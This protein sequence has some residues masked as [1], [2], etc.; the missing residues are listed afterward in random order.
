MRYTFLRSFIF[1][2]LSFNS[3]FSNAQYFGR[4][5]VLYEDFDFR[6]NR[7]PHFDI[8][9]YLENENQKQLLAWRTEQW[10]LMHM[11]VLRDSFVERNPFII[12]NHHAHFQQTRVIGGQIDVSTGGVTEGFKN[13][14]IMPFMESNA[15]TDHVLGHELVHAFQYHII[16][17]SFSLNA[18]NNLPLWMVEGMAEYLS[19]GY[20]DA[21]TA[22]WLRSALQNKR[23]PSL[24]DLTNRPDLY[25]PYRWGQAFWAYVSGLYGDGIIRKLFT[26][27]AANGYAAAI[28]KV[29]GMDEATF[30]KQWQE[31][32]RNAYSPFQTKTQPA[33]SGNSLINSNNAGELNIVPSI[34]PDG[35]YIAYWTEKNL[36][37]LDLFIANA[38]TGEVTERITRNSYNAHIDQY[39]SYESKVAWSPDSRQIAFVVFA[40]GRNELVVADINGK[41]TQ[42]LRIPGVDGFSNPAWSPDGKTIVLTGLVEGQSDLYAYS[43]QN[44]TV[45]KLTN[46]IYAD[47]HPSFSPDGKYIVFSTDRISIGNNTLQHRYNHNLAL[48]NIATGSITNLDFFPGADNLNPVFAP[49]N[50]IIY[51]LSDRDGFRNIYSYDLQDKTLQQKTNLFTGITGI[52]SFAPAISVS[53]QTGKLAYSYFSNGSYTIITAVP[54]QLE[55]IE[56]QP[57]N[58]NRAAAVLPPL[59]RLGK[60]IVQNNLSTPPSLTAA[61]TTITE[62]PY[63]SKFELDYLG[64]T[65]IGIQTGGSFGTGLAGGVNGIFSD[66]LGNHQMFGALSLSGEILDFGGQFA[67]INQNN[68]INWGLSASHIPYLSGAEYLFPDTV[69]NVQGDTIEVINNSLDLL[70]TFEDQLS[71]FASYPF[72]TIRRI[73]LGASF[74]RYYYRMDRYT[75]YY[76]P[77]GTIYLGNTREKQPVPGGFNFGNSYLAYVGDN[78]FFGVASPLAGHRFRLQA[79]QYFGVVNMTNLMGDYRKYFRMEPI[80]LATRN[81]YVGRFGKDAETGILA[82]LFLGYPTLIRGYDAVGYKDDKGGNLTIN[83]LIGS[84]IYVS[85]V[86]LRLPLTGPER[87][88]AITSRFLFTEIN[89]FTDG[90]IAWGQRNPAPGIDFKQESFINRQSRFILSSGISLRLNLFG[91]LILEP[92][93]AVPWQNGGFKNTNFGF[94][95]VPGW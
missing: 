67:Y 4:N 19:I 39:S 53:H 75:D 34:S 50:R 56:L 72:S 71:V 55:T 82:P 35:R 64:N 95:F 80:T 29:L 9:N 59:A 1:F 77:S 22:I 83:D 3:L 21:H 33:P 79:G 81:L 51:F 31:A 12:Y 28:Q 16:K 85:N 11:Q 23:L 24:K 60:D 45:K 84:R 52:T 73:E 49:G 10:F 30:S 8:Y 57:A 94:N 36:F 13:R 20:I 5:K 63:K 7:T 66:M 47:I 38:E 37:T 65:G 90:G 62:L 70:R 41:I 17:D 40:K 88:S 74:A 54:S 78:S 61:Q 87:L 46:D 58:G 86:E 48:L 43:F 2:L 91:Y 26:E 89:L 14:V 44:K 42:Q 92:Y 25:F 32:I 69:Q 18:L 27:T 15:Q 6:I 93:V 76:D 68:R